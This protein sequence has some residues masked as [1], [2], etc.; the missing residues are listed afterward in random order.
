MERE[1]FLPAA[2]PSKVFKGN[3]STKQIFDKCKL[4]RNKQNQK[5]ERE[6]EQCWFCKESI[7]PPES[8]FKELHSIKLQIL[9]HLSLQIIFKRISIA[10]T[11]SE[12]DD[13]HEK[14]NCICS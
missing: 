7:L 5:R 14:V 8:N 9:Q 2:L 11:L 4:L 1:R 13:Q 10:K 6:R 3:A 12:I